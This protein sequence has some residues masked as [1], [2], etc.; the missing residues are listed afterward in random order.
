MPS[1]IWVAP[2]LTS[3]S[4]LDAPSQ[5]T[6]PLPFLPLP[7]ISHSAIF[8]RVRSCNGRLQHAGLLVLTMLWWSW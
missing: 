8:T 1:W 5:S 2:S 7:Q 3:T 4:H 6:L